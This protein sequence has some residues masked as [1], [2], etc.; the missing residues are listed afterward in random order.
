M[1]IIYSIF[2]IFF[3]FFKVL[4]AELLL[5][6]NLKNSLENLYSYSPKLKYEREILKSKD[7]LYPQA[8]SDFRPEVSG[9]Y[10]KGKI[11]TNSSGFNIT[12]DGVRTETNKGLTISQ[13]LFDGGSTLSKIN[14]ARDEIKAQRYFLRQVE[15]DVFLEAIKLYGDLATEISN[16]KLN[17]KNMEFLESQFDLTK[18]QFEIGEVTLT[19]VSISDAR[20]SLGKSEILKTKSKI[21]SM[22]AKYFAL[23]GISPNNPNID[24][25]FNKKNVFDIEE[26]KSIIKKNNPN[27][28]NTYFQVKSSENKIKSL[29]RKRLPSVKLEA[30]AKI[31]RGYFRTDSE[32]EVLSAYTKVDIPLYQSGVAASKIREEK[33]KLFALKELLNQKLKQ[34]EFNLVSSISNFNYSFSRIEAYEKQIKSNKIFLDGLKQELL[35]GERTT[36]DL[37]DGEQ[38]LLQSQLDLVKSKKDLFISYYETLFYLGKLNARSLNLDVVY[39][40][41]MEN[42]NKVK[43]KWLDF[44]E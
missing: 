38:E 26:S 23:F 4:N 3:L 5:N 19:D 10:E 14:S 43:Y 11:D 37:L 17:K 12:S 6:K 9:Y 25:N 32:R 40:N 31:N 33:K 20:Y 22:T 35:L 1:K 41:E 13:S 16:L 24:A 34:V 42:F 29:K 21:E 27:I 7:E 8:L 15:Q 36:L 28:Q 44:I 39:F 2:F 18:Q 30:E